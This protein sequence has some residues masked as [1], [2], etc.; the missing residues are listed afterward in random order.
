[1]YYEAAVR[2]YYEAGSET[3]IGTASAF[4][5]TISL[6]IFSVLCWTFIALF[7]GKMFWIGS[8]PAF[9][10]CLSLC[11]FP[12]WLCFNRL[13][14]KTAPEYYA[15]GPMDDP[16]NCTECITTMFMLTPVWPTLTLAV[17]FLTWKLEGALNWSWVLVFIPIWV[18]LSI[19]S[20]MGWS[21]LCRSCK[22]CKK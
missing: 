17:V 9:L 6:C 5:I 7:F 18:I 13:S 3:E 15:P 21:I 20:L 8:L 19:S 10:G 2:S 22:C 16:G 1:V 11:M 4:S 12:F 14:I